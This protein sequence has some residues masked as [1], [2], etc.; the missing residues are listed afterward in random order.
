MRHPDSIKHYLQEDEYKVYKL[1]WQRFVASQ[2]LPAIFDQTSVD[3]DAVSDRTYNFRVTGSVLK[4][5]GFLKVYE[6]AKEGKDEDDEALK[7]KDRKSTRL[8]SSHS[9]ISYA[10][11]CLKKK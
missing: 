1:I 7:H 4:F 3:I 5:E 9:Q 10:V 2:M 8:N 11:F 6:E